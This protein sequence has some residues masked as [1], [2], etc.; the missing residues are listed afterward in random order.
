MVAPRA[1]GG[2]PSSADGGGVGCGRAPAG[3][4]CV[5]AG[6][7]V[8]DDHF[9]VAFLREDAVGEELAVG[10]EA[11]AGDGP[12]AVVIVVVQ[13][14]LGFAQTTPGQAPRR[15]TATRTHEGSVAG[16]T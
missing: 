9:A 6:D 14:P 7:E 2:G 4:C 12:P 1:C 16:E 11:L 3:S 15:L 5:L 10:G 13:G 8:A